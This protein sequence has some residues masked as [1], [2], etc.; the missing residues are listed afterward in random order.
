MTFSHILGMI[1]GREE[2]ANEHSDLDTE[3]YPPPF[4]SHLMD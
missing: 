2:E 4:L 1:Q 3:I